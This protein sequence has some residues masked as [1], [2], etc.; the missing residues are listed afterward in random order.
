MKKLSTM[1]IGLGMWN[2]GTSFR[3]REWRGHKEI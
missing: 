1:K 3:G 2:I